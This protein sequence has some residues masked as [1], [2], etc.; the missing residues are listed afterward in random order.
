ML[1]LFLLFLVLVEGAAIAALFSNVSHLR[2][3]LLR[4]EAPSAFTPAPPRLVTAAQGWAPQRDWAPPRAWTPPAGYPAV[5][6]YAPAMAAQL[7]LP[8]AAPTPAATP[9]AAPSSVD[10]A[11]PQGDEPLGAAPDMAPVADVAEQAP[12]IDW[13]RWLGV[14]G[15]AAV[16]AVLLVVA[17]LYFLRYSI[18][19]G[20]LSVAARVQLGAGLSVAAL[21]GSRVRLPRSHPVLASWIAGAGIAGLYASAWAGAWL[22]HLYGP[23]VAFCLAVAITI[24]AVTLALRAGSLPIALLGFV[25][26]FA[27]PLALVSGGESKAAIVV[28]VLL[29]DLGAVVL[30]MKKRWW[31]LALLSVVVSAGY[32]AVFL[33]SS[34]SDALMPLHFG[35]A[36]AFA[37]LFGLAP[38]FGRRLV[39]DPTPEGDAMPTPIARALTYA[40]LLASFGLSAPLALKLP[41]GFAGLP[42]VGLLFVLTGASAALARRQSEPG[43]TLV[44]AVANVGV[45]F[46]WSLLGEPT[47]AANVVL[48]LGAVALTVPIVVYAR[49]GALASDAS[50]TTS[51]R[52]DVAPTGAV[53]VAVVGGAGLVCF[54]AFGAAPSVAPILALGALGALLVY[55]AARGRDEPLVVVAT[56]GTALGLGVLAFARAADPVVPLGASM[57]LSAVAAAGAAVAA[58][59]DAE[60]LARSLASGARSAA[61]VGALAL[62]PVVGAVSFGVVAALLST[63]VVVVLAARPAAS[64]RALVALGPVV[65]LTLVVRVLDA[66]LGV[67]PGPVRGLGALLVAALVVGPWIVARLRKESAPV[68]LPV[69]QTAALASLAV[70]FGAASIPGAASALDE[71]SRIFILVAVASTALLAVHA[72]EGAGATAERSL[73]PLALLAAMGAAVSGFDHERSAIALSVLGAALLVGRRWVSHRALLAL[74]GASLALGAISLAPNP[75]ALEFHPRASVPILNWTLLVWGLPTFAAIASVVRLTRETEGGGADP[76]V[77]RARIVAAVASLA[78]VFAWINVVVLDVFGTGP[79]LSLDAASTWSKAGRDLAMSGVWAAF[80]VGLLVLG[81]KRRSGSLRK[82]SLGVVLLTIGK[83]FLYDLSALENLYRVASLVGLALS[84][85]GISVLYQRFVFKGA[86]KPEG[87]AS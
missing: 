83:V 61:I 14:R 22:A 15:A 49:R 50:D 66:R 58:R 40:S 76:H 56:S 54:R 44:A 3:R 2:T 28:Y 13:E 59:R 19:A 34:G 46:A 73:A 48:A 65:A 35:I 69:A 45:L 43:L 68:A 5:E 36:V 37:A 30:A 39:G 20:W 75:L 84:L 82:V 80:G 33:Y 63:A 86:P 8:F 78:L 55:T 24:V 79:V 53:F 57:V 4:L 11:L 16:G 42:L 77:G 81:M 26:A 12:P 71:A 18:D 7:S 32:E 70:T 85:I 67:A 87:P 74:G 31:S 9:L 62:A 23:V 41:V 1:E 27:A 60:P 38:S 10:S 47:G 29:L 64:G 21:V 17:L 52:T 72:H 25:G 51:A 6:P